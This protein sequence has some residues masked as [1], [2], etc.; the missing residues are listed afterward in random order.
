VQ[1]TNSL[2][3]NNPCT[4]LTAAVASYVLNQV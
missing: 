2:T 1:Q 3:S 4:K